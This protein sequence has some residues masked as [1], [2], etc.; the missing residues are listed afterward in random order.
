M[1]PFS[2]GDEAAV[3]AGGVAGE[4]KVKTFTLDTNCIIDVA[5]SRPSKP[6]I[7]ALRDAHFSGK[8]NVAVVGISASEK[9]KAGGFL[10]TFETFQ[11]ELRTLGLDCLEIL[12]PIGY[13]D[14]TYM[15]WCVWSDPSL[16]ALER[17][18]H[19]AM[20]PK[21]HFNRTD[22]IAYSSRL[23]KNAEA[24]WRNQK[25]DVLALV[26]HALNRREI[27]VTRDADFNGAKSISGI[28]QIVEPAQ[29]AAMI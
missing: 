17:A 13:S 26:S 23:P 2:W 24:E 7:L 18:I 29:A 11:E 28:G 9:Q 3:W 1:M 22:H 27:F 5:E 6:H 20:F 19:T 4:P 15:D 12:K 14:I 16:V 10:A 8:A 25:C 21:A